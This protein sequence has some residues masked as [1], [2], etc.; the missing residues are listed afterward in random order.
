MKVKEGILEPGVSSLGD[1]YRAIVERINPEG[2]AEHQLRQAIHDALQ[3][4]G[5]QRT[6]AIFEEEAA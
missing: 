3:L 2:Y 5:K 1:N 6:A 4:I